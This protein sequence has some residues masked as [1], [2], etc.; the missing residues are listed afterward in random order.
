VFRNERGLFRLICVARAFLPA[1]SVGQGEAGEEECPYT[2]TMGSLFLRVCG[3]AEVGGQECPPHTMSASHVLGSLDSQ[4]TIF[5][6]Y[7][8]QTPSDCCPRKS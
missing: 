6:G 3:L 4:P 5:F 1:K 7:L 2:L 8:H